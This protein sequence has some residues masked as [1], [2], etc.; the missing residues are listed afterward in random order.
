VAFEGQLDEPPA[1]SG[2]VE[3]VLGRHRREEADRG[4][5]GDRV[6][7][8]HVGLLAADEEVDRAKPRLIER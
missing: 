4:E 5:A 2:E 8:G 7:L 1:D 3:T 6:D